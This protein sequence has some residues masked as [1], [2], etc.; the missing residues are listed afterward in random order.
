VAARI[1]PIAI[2]AALTATSAAALPSVTLSKTLGHIAST[3]KVG[4]SGFG[5]GEAVDIYFDTTDLM[6]VT[7][8]AGGVFANRSITIPNGAQPGIHWIT[9]VG[10]RDGDAGQSS[11]KVSSTWGSIGFDER[12]RRRNPWENV[13]N[14]Q[15]V[16][17]LDLLWK[18]KT[19][20]EVVSS[21]AYYNGIVYVGSWD[22]SLYAL[23]AATGSVVWKKATGG[24]IGAS[25]AIGNGNVY[26]SSENGR[27]YAF[28]AATGASVWTTGNMNLL[29][30]SPVFY[31]NKV[32][33]GSSD[34]T[35]RARNASTGGFAWTYSTGN[36]IDS[37]PAISG[38]TLYVVNSSGALYGLDPGNGSALG[39][40]STSEPIVSSIA[41][42]NGSLYVA[43]T[44]GT[45]C[46][47]NAG[48]T[49]GFC[50]GL[51]AGSYASP[52]IA[53]GVLYIGADDGKL[54][55]LDPVTLDT[56]W[57][58]TSGAAVR[59]SPAVADSAVFQ[60][61]RDGV[62]FVGSGDGYIYGIDADK[63]STGTA[64]WAAQ[65]GGAVESSPTVADGMMFV[66]SD[67][68]HV[69]A[70]ALN[71]GN[72]PAYRRNTKPPSFTDLHPDLRL[73]PAH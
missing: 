15:N 35:L 21:P 63:A 48:L 23:D 68:D 9:A 66:G 71:G 45:I 50:I 33:V 34:G 73:K 72:N 67:D 52:A 36:A 42:A 40:I 43:G 13:I 53:N 55:A 16:Q 4:G 3:T 29:D 58:Y 14:D 28:N 24:K 1:A 7:T 61:N 49:G 46:N 22:K 5:A 54:Y 30:A 2:F 8:S 69:Y 38:G 17:T 26:V 64:L 18:A 37:A 20:D 57:T 51:G 65:T 11:F 47:L 39:A 19:G 44:S 12:G 32:Y 31:D 6:L 10:R 56:K 25:P 41:A 27:L 62:V 59:S 60:G 70:Y